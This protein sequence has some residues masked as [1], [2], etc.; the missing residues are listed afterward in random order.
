MTG[1]IPNRPADAAGKASGPTRGGGGWGG[2]GAERRNPAM[3]L[4]LVFGIGVPLAI[5][6]MILFGI[7]W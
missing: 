3:V 1:W 2:G 4:A 5:L 6:V 7:A